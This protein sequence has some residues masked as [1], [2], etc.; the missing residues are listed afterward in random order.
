MKNEAAESLKKYFFWIIIAILLFVSFLIIKPFLIALLSSFVLAYLIRPIHKT[1]SKKVN[2]KFAA[3]LSVIII[4]GLILLP[5][6]FILYGLITQINFSLGLN[7]FSDKLPS[8]INATLFNSLKEKALSLMFSLASSIISYLPYLI[9]ST[10]ISLLSIYYILISWNYLSKKVE[11]FIPFKDK[12]R[13][14]SEIAEKTKGIVHGYLFIAILEFIVAFIGFYISGVKAFLLLPMLISLLAFVPGL[15]PGVVWVP[16]ALYYF[17]TQ[18]YLTA[19]GVL[20]T[21]LII[22]IVI[23]T[24]LL[25]KIVGKDSKIHPLIFLMGVLG[26]VPLFGLF[27]F[28]IGPLILVYALKII[29]E[30]TE[31]NQ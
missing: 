2:E 29:D 15:G 26:G 10:L 28:I 3:F 1:L 27:G 11:S 21:G 16:T 12:K 18:Q 6:F 9:I 5:L 30:I 7:S 20:I 8:F 25:G 17:L 31:Q 14:S 4:L 19:L 24:I 13:V 23:E 22:S